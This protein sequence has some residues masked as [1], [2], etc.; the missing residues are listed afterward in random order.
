MTAEGAKIIERTKKELCTSER[1][2]EALQTRQREVFFGIGHLIDL[3]SLV[4][5]DQNR[6]P[7][8]FPSVMDWIIE[9]VAHFR[10]AVAEED[11]SST[12]LVNPQVFMA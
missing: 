3:L 7:K 12:D 11:F 1:E 8:N 2:M 10:K 4:M 9:T 5:P 6:I